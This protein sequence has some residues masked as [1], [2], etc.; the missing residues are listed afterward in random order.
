MNKEQIYDADIAPLMARIIDVCKQNG[1]AMIFS[2]AIPTET[3]SGLCCT[4]CLPDGDG[5]NWPEHVAAVRLL[6]NERQALQMR[7]EH[8]DGSVTM[9]AIL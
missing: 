2:A 8:G 9:A 4:T 7:S 1:I 6:R 3:D 5:N